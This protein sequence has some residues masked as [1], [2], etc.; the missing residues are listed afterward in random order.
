VIQAIQQVV[1]FLF[2]EACIE[3]IA[4][5]LQHASSLTAHPEFNSCFRS[6]VQII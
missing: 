5:G 4:K 1:I 6:Q 3:S 2:R